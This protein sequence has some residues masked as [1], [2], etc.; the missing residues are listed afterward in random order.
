MHQA[1]T[2]LVDQPGAWDDVRPLMQAKDE[3]TFSALKGAFLDG[4]PHKSRGDE[5]KDAQAFFATLSKLGGSAL[6]GTATSLPEG[7][8][9]DQAVYG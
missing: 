6:V 4:I 5:I 7:L 9:V 2:L 8:Y 1:E 3:A